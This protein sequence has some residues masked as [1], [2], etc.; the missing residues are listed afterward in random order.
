MTLSKVVTSATRSRIPMRLMT[1]LYPR[2]RPGMPS[3]T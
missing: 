1:C 2:D 3:T